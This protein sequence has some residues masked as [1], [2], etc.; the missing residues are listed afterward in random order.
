[1]E[2]SGAAGL[3]KSTPV[4][5]PQAADGITALAEGLQ[6]GAV[7]PQEALG[8]LLDLAAERVPESMRAQIRSELEAAL[9][10]D[11]GLAER[12]KRLGIL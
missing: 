2:T 11:P 9:R 5:L 4:T 10:E 6:S 1:M 7:K 3:D 12:A 8:R